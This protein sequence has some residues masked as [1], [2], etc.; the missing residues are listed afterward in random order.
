MVDK[1]MP[2]IIEWAC[3]VCIPITI[4]SLKKLWFTK[5]SSYLSANNKIVSHQTRGTDS[6]DE[7]SGSLQFCLVLLT[8]TSILSLVII[9][10]FVNEVKKN[11]KSNTQHNNKRGLGLVIGSHLVPLCYMAIYTFAFID[12]DSCPTIEE[13]RSPSYDSTSKGLH[14]LQFASL[15]GL[16]F[17]LSI[18]WMKSSQYNHRK[19][20]IYGNSDNGSAVKNGQVKETKLY[21]ATTMSMCWKIYTVLLIVVSC[22]RCVLS[23]SGCDGSTILFGLIHIM[24]I[25]LYDQQN[26]QTQCKEQQ[27]TTSQEKETA[28]QDAFTFGEWNAIATLITS[29]VGEY[30]VEYIYN[31][32]KEGEEATIST[33]LSLPT[34]IIV[35]H[36]G[37]VGCLVGVALCSFTK[38]LVLSN[39]VQQNNIIIIRT[40]G[41]LTSLVIVVGVTVVCLEVAL[42]SNV[43]EDA[44]CGID[45]TTCTANNI[46]NWVLLPLSIQW[47]LHFLTS[48]KDMPSFSGYSTIPS[49]VLILGY[50]IALLAICLPL[51]SVLMSW[52]TSKAG[53]HN[54]T[55]NEN[56]VSEDINNHITKERKKRVIIARKYFH[57]VAIL[58]FTP[59][60]YLDHD[61]MSL[62]YAIAIS[63]LIV[64]EMIRG[65][66]DS[67]IV[68]S[69]KHWNNV[70]T[71]FLDE[72]DSRGGLVVSHIAL[73][74]GCAIPLWI[75]QLLSRANDVF[76]SGDNNMLFTLLPYLGITVLGVGDSAAAIGGI[77]F[78]RH[79]WPGESSR[80]LEGSC[81]MFLSMMVVV[82]TM[83]TF[84][85][86]ANITSTKVA[87]MG[88]ITLLEASTIQIDN[89]VLP[90]AGLTLVLFL[91][92]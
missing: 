41:M 55:A 61:M 10:F 20:N 6:Y 5:L 48:E 76:K 39:S 2:L 11:N 37:L 30:I 67:N 86:S 56:T 4:L 79:N 57:V 50:W 60:T 44:F 17:A 33:R 91:N 82:L 71:T 83:G 80:T 15:G 63:F 31:P 8:V 35:A 85:D 18:L 87:T 7:Y 52:I 26:P 40:I 73:I 42:K 65:W 69:T 23:S 66:I 47:I 89:F 72:K 58:L 21:Q 54:K 3:I 46:I 88:V 38:K 19:C 22:T 45:S 81:C 62:S 9:L 53:L 78:G 32:E 29:L 49:R 25:I 70:Y 16:S 92:T 77:Q 13:G 27:H 84:M 24:L 1:C 12:R 43:S 64:L 51:S 14:H 90:V 75:T 36:A 68:D 28:W 34:H 74:L 59:I